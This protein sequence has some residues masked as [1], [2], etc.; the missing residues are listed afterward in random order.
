MTKPDRPRQPASRRLNPKVPLTFYRS[1]DAQSSSDSPF[2]V[3]EKPAPS[4]FKRFF[5]DFFD[6]LLII[7]LL[8]G[9]FYS[10][11]IKPTPKIVL[12]SEVYHSSSTYKQAAQEYLSSIKNRNKVTFDDQSVIDSMQ[13][14]FPEIAS[15]YV[16]LPVFAQSP[17]VHL[18]ISQPS[19]ILTSNNNSLV[20]TADGFAVNEAGKFSGQKLPVVQ[21][22]SGFNPQ[23]GKQVMSASSVKFIS[24]LLVELKHA[25][26][27]VS[28]LFLPP[29]AQELDMR[30]V[31]QPYYVKFYMGGDVLQQSGQ[32][33]AARHQFQKD[34]TKPAEYLDV[35]V[36]GKVYF[37]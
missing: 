28:Q 1:G 17:I 21:D 7:G 32:F 37:K 12:N 33:L 24:N 20:V 25:N 9:L 15:S 11:T 16:E 34:D 2:K 30:T 26:V 4:K 23:A 29:K 13:R 6:V 10:L 5:T 35:R 36:A 27:Q 22:Q 14:Q 19:L 8:A 3:K 31:D 18:N